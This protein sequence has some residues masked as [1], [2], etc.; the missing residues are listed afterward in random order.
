MNGNGVAKNASINAQRAPPEGWSAPAVVLREM[1][2]CSRKV[3]KTQRTH[4]PSVVQNR[5]G[6]PKNS[7]VVWVSLFRSV[8]RKRSRRDPTFSRGG[9]IEI[10]SIHFV[11]G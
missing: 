9:L 11:G 7:A 8:L 6:R 4:S 3:A 10:V 1:V 5:R 2:L